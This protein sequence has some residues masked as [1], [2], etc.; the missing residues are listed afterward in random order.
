MPCTR[1]PVGLC[2][3]IPKAWAGLGQTPV[4]GWR[5]KHRAKLRRGFAQALPMHSSLGMPVESLIGA[6]AWALLTG[7]VPSTNLH[8]FHF[9]FSESSCRLSVHIGNWKFVVFI[10]STIVV[11]PPGERFPLKA[12]IPIFMLYITLYKFC[13]ATSN[14]LGSTLRLWPRPQTHTDFRLT[15]LNYWTFISRYT[16]GAL[17]YLSATPWRGKEIR[18][19]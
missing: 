1:A 12:V 8:Q 17:V 6:C 7:L 18:R 16:L 19:A 10:G 15:L 11:K 9:K 5:M 2:V 14:G 4:A 13:L 3:G